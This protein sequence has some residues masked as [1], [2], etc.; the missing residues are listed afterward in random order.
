MK[1][2]TFIALLII[3]VT[4]AITLF[5]H[6][7]DFIWMLGLWKLDPQN[8]GVL[9]GYAVQLIGIISLC[10]FL[11]T[12]SVGIVFKKHWYKALIRTLIASL[13]FAGF[14]I[15]QD[16]T[17]LRIYVENVSLLEKLYNPIKNFFVFIIINLIASLFLTRPKV[18]E[19]FK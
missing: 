15:F 13:L 8:P 5:I 11:I 14:I 4:S 19:Q 2:L 1:K 17:Y 3:L 7:K 10:V 12:F 9:V 16:N 6:I 18:K